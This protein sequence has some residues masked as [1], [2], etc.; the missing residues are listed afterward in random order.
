MEDGWK[1]QP[2]HREQPRSTK[3]G[4]SQ[5]WISSQICVYR[6]DLQHQ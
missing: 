5:I 2:I 3:L 4:S 1:P 6:M